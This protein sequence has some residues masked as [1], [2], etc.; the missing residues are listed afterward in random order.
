[1]KKIW[2][3]LIILLTMLIASS[4]NRSQNNSKEEMEED[5]E[6]TQVDKGRN[7]QKTKKTP[8]KKYAKEGTAWGDG[9]LDISAII[10]DATN[11]ERKIICN[12][13]MS[14]VSKDCDGMFNMYKAE[15]NYATNIYPLGMN[16]DTCAARFR[17]VYRALESRIEEKCDKLLVEFIIANTQK[18]GCIQVLNMEEFIYKKEY[19]KK[20]IRY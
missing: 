7:T 10:I 14:D 1:M 12:T 17:P 3:L 2:F 20:H 18:L 4:C 19:C 13:P 9:S 6:Y 5:K 16:L 15:Y 11:D 8:D